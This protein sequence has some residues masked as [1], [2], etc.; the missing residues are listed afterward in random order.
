MKRTRKMASTLICVIAGFF[1][2]LLR[3]QELR[4]G[5]DEYGLRTGCFAR[6]ALIALSVGA[7][8]FA[9]VNAVGQR[10]QSDYLPNLRIGFPGFSVSTIAVAGML[11][12]ALLHFWQE[13]GNQAQMVLWIFGLAAALC[14]FIS[15]VARMQEKT[16][17]LVLH[18][19]PAIFLL[20]LLIV[21]FR[22][23][24][25]DPTIADY[26]YKLFALIA[27]L[28]AVF[29]LGGFCFGAGKRRMTM[30][31]A[32]LA[33]YFD[34]VVLAD[35]GLAAGFLMAGYGLYLAVCLSSLHSADME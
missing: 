18:L 21:R 1:G 30:F 32:S 24:S 10:K 14:L 25:I 20:A 2:M 7:V 15:A 19:L 27:T 34:F 8:A 22:G 9:A 33:I 13:R 11:I 4:T 6:W 16:P 23:W 17:P 26:C 31:W 28:L 3:M 5:F 29:H 35:G 12:G